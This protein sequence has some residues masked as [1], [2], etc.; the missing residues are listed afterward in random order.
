MWVAS[1]TFAV[2]NSITMFREKIRDGLLVGVVVAFNKNKCRL[3]V[4]QKSGCSPN[5][6]QLR[7]FNINFKDI[8]SLQ[9]VICR[10]FREIDY[11]HIDHIYRVTC[12]TN[13]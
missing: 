9:I 11:L 7:S 12:Q 13:R 4:V 5:C 2:V 10:V 3:V 8:H 1:T 6:R